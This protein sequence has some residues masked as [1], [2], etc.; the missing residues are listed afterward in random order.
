MEKRPILPNLLDS[1]VGCAIPNPTA[2]SRKISINVTTK[3]NDREKNMYKE[4]ICLKLDQ[5]KGEL[6]R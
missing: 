2:G 5:R 3:E 4:R 1:V 6:N